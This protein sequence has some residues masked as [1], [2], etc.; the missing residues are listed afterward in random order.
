MGKHTNML[1][2]KICEQQKLDSNGK[3]MCACEYSSVIYLLLFILGHLLVVC[4]IN[5]I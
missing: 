3:T 5:S 1:S 4:L 2:S